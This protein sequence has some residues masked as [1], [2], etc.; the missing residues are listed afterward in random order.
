MLCK[1]SIISLF[2]MV[3]CDCGTNKKHGGK[4]V[5]MGNFVPGFYLWGQAICNMDKFGLLTFSD[6]LDV[7]ALL[8]LLGTDSFSTCVEFGL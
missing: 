1:A 5:V 4:H 2:A 3:A 6:G 8:P 7:L